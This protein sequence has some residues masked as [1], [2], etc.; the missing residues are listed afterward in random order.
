MTVKLPE[1]ALRAAIALEDWDRARDILAGHEQAVKA[2]MENPDSGMD[3]DAWI[4][5]Q[6]QQRALYS[7]LALSRNKVS[8]LLNSLA[9]KNQRARAYK[10]GGL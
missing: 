10:K 9:S 1:H 3:A 7:E 8:Q 4:A 6:Q 2:A 5:L